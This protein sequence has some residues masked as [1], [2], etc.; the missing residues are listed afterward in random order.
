MALKS[1]RIISLNTV[2]MIFVN[3]WI[4]IIMF[5]LKA[6]FSYFAV[7]PHTACAQERFCLLSMDFEMADLSKGH[8]HKKQYDFLYSWY[9][10]K[11][12]LDKCLENLCYCNSDMILSLVCIFWSDD[13]FYCMCDICISIYLDQYNLFRLFL[14]FITK[15]PFTS[16][17]LSELLI[18]EKVTTVISV[19]SAFVHL[20]RFSIAM[21]QYINASSMPS[22][23]V[24]T[25]ILFKQSV[26]F[27]KVLVDSSTVICS[28]VNF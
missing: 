26:E 13:R 23:V 15:P 21:S 28:L 5:A 1:S 9:I 11:L 16:S 24:E 10:S 2:V 8:P 25:F 7:L 6:S 27:V 12:I 18:N 20:F 4:F 17:D 14:L 22:R 19:P 3:C